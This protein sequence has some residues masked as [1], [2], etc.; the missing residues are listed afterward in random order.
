MLGFMMECIATVDS[1]GN[2]WPVMSTSF[3]IDAVFKYIIGNL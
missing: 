2:M 3:Y 1:Q